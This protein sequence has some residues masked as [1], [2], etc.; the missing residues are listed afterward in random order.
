VSEVPRIRKRRRHRTIRMQRRVPAAMVEVQVSVDYKSTSSGRIPPPQRRGRSSWLQWISRISPAALLPIRSR[1]ARLLAVRTTTVFSP[2]EYGSDRPAVLA[3]PTR[4]SAPRQTW[5]AVQLV[6]PSV[7][8]VSSK[9]QA[10]L[11]REPV[12]K[13]GQPMGRPARCQDSYL[14]SLTSYCERRRS[15]QDLLL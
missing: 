9:S 8:T 3:S 1:S 10:A 12:P 2:A 15:S 6:V 7:Q 13:P 5:A 14:S 11:V 4:A